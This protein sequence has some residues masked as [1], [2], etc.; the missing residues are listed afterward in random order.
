MSVAA[1]ILV[2]MI[3]VD[4]DVVMVVAGVQIMLALGRVDMVVAMVIKDER[5]VFEAKSQVIEP[6]VSSSLVVPA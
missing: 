2:E 3:D 5:R 6:S 4:V 1:M